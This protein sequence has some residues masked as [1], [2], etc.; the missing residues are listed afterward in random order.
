MTA[1]KPTES[2]LRNL[3]D[4][5]AYNTVLNEINAKYTE[6]DKYIGN[7]SS[8]IMS[9]RDFEND[10]LADKARGYDVGTSLDTLGF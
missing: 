3:I 5:D 2:E 7:L 4:A 9:I 1:I 6:M 8:D 10:M